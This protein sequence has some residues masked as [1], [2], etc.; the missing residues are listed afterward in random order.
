MQFGCDAVSKVNWICAEPKKGCT[1]WTQWKWTGV[2]L[3][4]GNC[5]NVNRQNKNGV[6]VS[7]FRLCVWCLKWYQKDKTKKWSKCQS[8]DR[9]FFTDKEERTSPDDSP[10]LSTKHRKQASF[11]E[12]MSNRG[13]H[14]HT[15]GNNP[16]SEWKCNCNWE[17]THAHKCCHAKTGHSRRRRF[18]NGHKIVVM[19]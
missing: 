12:K 14:A 16:P 10:N 17:W 7:C 4:N 5:P 8:I 6:A 19:K 3:T 11:A 9:S 13:R 18:G 2:D 15:H 1:V